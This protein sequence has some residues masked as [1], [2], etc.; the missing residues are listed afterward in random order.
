M[1]TNANSRPPLVATGERLMTDNRGPNVPEHLHRYALACELA[2]GRDVIDVASG[3][4]FCSML[5]A[6]HAASVVGVDICAEAIAHAAAKYKRD[7]L[8][9]VRGSATDLPLPGGSVDLVVSFETIEHLQ[10]HE[11]MLREVRRVLRPGGRLIMSSPDKRHYSEATGHDNP[12]HVH[13]LHAAEFLEL[14]SRHFRHV[15]PF[16]QRVVHGSLIVPAEPGPAFTEYRGDFA[17]F[18]AEPRLREAMYVIVVAADEPLPT[19]AS[20][21]LWDATDLLVPSRRRHRAFRLPRGNL[22]AWLFGARRDRG[23]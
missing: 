4:G 8:R 12:F 13:E 7:N 22:F 3:E 6:G 15:R 14:M 11:A 20:A 16:F 2:Q 5:L 9:F 23:H 21:S 18:T 10:D 1:M 19:S 17:E